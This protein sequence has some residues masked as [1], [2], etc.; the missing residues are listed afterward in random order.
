MSWCSTNHNFDPDVCRQQDIPDDLCTLSPQ[1]TQCVDLTA[2]ECSA[3]QLAPSAMPS[4]V[5]CQA[6]CAPTCHEVPAYCAP[7]CRDD[8]LKC[9]ALFTCSAP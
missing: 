5:Q 6:D 8:P 7:I 3:L 1:G 9:Y 4:V 2:A